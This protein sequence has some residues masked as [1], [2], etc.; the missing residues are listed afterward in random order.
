MPKRNSK[1]A[2]KS[3]PKDTPITR[4]YTINLHRRILQIAFKRRAPRAIREIKKFAQK[5]FF[6]KDVR[7][8]V[9]LNQHIWSK[10]IRYLPN[11]IRVRLERKHNEDEDVKEMYTLVSHVNLPSIK[12]LVTQKVVAT[13]DELEK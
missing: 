3:V 2:R 6:T 1:K 7:I 11:K 13:E 12:G 5:E 8:D 9:G 4:D 10:G